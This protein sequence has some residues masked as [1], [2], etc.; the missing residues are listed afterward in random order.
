MLSKEDETKFH[1][2]SLQVQHLRAMDHIIARNNAFPIEQIDLW[3]DFERTGKRRLQYK[4]V[5]R[6]ALRSFPSAIVP[7][8]RVENMTD[9]IIGE[10]ERIIEFDDPPVLDVNDKYMLDLVVLAAVRF[11]DEIN[12]ALEQQKPVTPLELMPPQIDQ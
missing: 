9:V 8:M 4:L 11:V 2:L 12:S 10:T 7:R 6:Q 5:G 3:A 1:H